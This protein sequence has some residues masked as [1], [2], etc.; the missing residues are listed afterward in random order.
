M[1]RTAADSWE[2]TESR[3]RCEAVPMFDVMFDY[4]RMLTAVCD[5]RLSSWRA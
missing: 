1:G 4:G 5:I 3:K 2:P